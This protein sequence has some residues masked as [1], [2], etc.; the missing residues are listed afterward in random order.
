MI[1]GIASASAIRQSLIGTTVVL[2]Q[3]SWPNTEYEGRF[4]GRE[5]S[6]EETGTTRATSAPASL[7]IS[8]A[9]SNQVA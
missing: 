5:Y 9:N 7:K 2:V 4:A 8:C 3:A 6:L 1:A